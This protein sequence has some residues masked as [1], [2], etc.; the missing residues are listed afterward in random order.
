MPY[1]AFHVTSL[2]DFYPDSL[3]GRSLVSSY[4]VIAGLLET[5]INAEAA[6]FLAEPFEDHKNNSLVWHSSAEG[7]IRSFESLSEGE[8]EAARRELKVREGRLS[9]LSAGLLSSGS[10][11]RREAGLIIQKLSESVR[12][13][14]NGASEGTAVYMAG[15]KLVLAGWG[16][17]K[18][19]LKSRAEG[20]S[21]LTEAYNPERAVSSEAPPPPVPLAYGYGAAGR[22]Q[23]GE[24]RLGD[25]G[26][27]G[28]RP[29]PA[30]PERRDRG[31]LYLILAALISFPLFLLLL[32]LLF[33]GL[34]PNSGTFNADVF[35][36]LNAEGERLR[37][38]LGVLKGIYNGNL[39][40]CSLR[41]ASEESREGEFSKREGIPKLLS[42]QGE[43]FLRPDATEEAAP[44]RVAVLDEDPPVVPKR[45][46]NERLVIPEDAGSLSF[47]E[48]CWTSMG[49]IHN[50]E[51][52]PVAYIY[53]FNKKGG[54][55][56]YIEEKNASGKVLDVCK[57]KAVATLAGKTL[58]I[59]D[60]GLKCSPGNGSYV[61][62]NV[63]CKNSD[64]GKDATCQVKSVSKGTGAFTSTFIYL[65][66][67]FKPKA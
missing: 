44:W 48:G 52:V 26:G 39:Y 60:N 65:G 2:S 49:S 6:G 5:E 36:E 16:L 21:F 62:I 45:I 22:P 23:S 38:E 59:S 41:G 34:I 57:G 47:M 8:K 55:D 25:P 15:G 10:P 67:S 43:D 3:E 50:T 42:E 54:A 31:L 51:K 14:L 46:P 61:P 56:V 35:D 19:S 64:S 24:G 40:A 17:R 20:S 4:G 1:K 28:F 9:A 33:P 18:A 11:Q 53:C 12:D 27:G 30:G 63:A 13:F 32:F 58:R 7:E 37:E 29:R 66:K